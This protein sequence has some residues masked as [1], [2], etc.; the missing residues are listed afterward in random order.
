[1]ATPPSTPI[2]PNPAV[3]EP[4]EP[5]KKERASMKPMVSRIV[6]VAVTLL[7]LGVIVGV[8]AM[9]HLD[10]LVEQLEWKSYDLRT[11]IQ[12]GDSP[13]RPSQDIVILQ[14]DDPSLS[15]L[16]DD[17]GTWPWPRD[18]HARMIRYMN[19]VGVRRMLYDIMFVS[20]RKGEEKQDKALVDAFW[21]S[22]NVYLS[23]NFDQGL[24]QNRKLGK[25]L[26]PHDIELL[27]P[28]SINLTSELDKAPRDTRLRL[29]REP[30]GSIFFDNDHMTFNHYRS[31]LP[32]LLSKG[33]NIAIINHGAD[34][35]GVSRGNPLFFRFRYNDFVKTPY[36]PI[37]HKANGWWY[38]Q[39]GQR[40]DA[41]GYLLQQSLY[42]IDKR[43]DQKRPNGTFLDTTPGNP[44]LV[45]KEG[46]LMDE[47]GHSIYKRNAASSFLY[48]PYLGFRVMLDLKYPKT[49][50]PIRLTP[51]GHLKFGS[52]NI[53]LAANGDCLVTWYNISLSREDQQRGLRE[54]S[55]YL[56]ILHN[57]LN[58]LEQ[59]AQ[60]NPT[61]INQ[62][63]LASHRLEVQKAEFMAHRLDQLLKRDF[64]PQP[65]RTVAA[66]EVIRAMRRSEAG[67]PPTTEDQVL[68]QKLRD[69]I[70]FVGTTAVATYDIKN[71]PIY[72]SFPGVIF[73]ATL[74]DNLSR[75]KPHYMQRANPET[76]QWILVAICL[77]A[78]GLTLRVRSALVGVLTTVNIAILYVLG[79]IVLYQSMSLWINVAML[80]VALI[81]T[82]TLTFIAKYMLRDKD[83]E[84]T[85]ALA[86]TDS[87]T[88]LYNHRFFQDSMRQSID[89]ASRFKHSFSLL[90]IDIDFFKRFNDTYG[91]QT[92]DEVLRHVARKLQ[93]SVRVIDIVA[94]YG[95]EE[96]A[97]I[98]ARA[99]EEEAWAV[100]NKI[101]KAVAE[102]THL[103]GSGEA[104]QVTISCGIATYPM[105]G[106]TPSQL[107]EVADAGLY[108]AK[109]NGRNQVGSL[110]EQAEPPTSESDKA[111]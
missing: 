60:Q 25:D 101:V 90:L 9:F 20:H 44:Q 18:V 85:Y 83:Y 15:V 26:T 5:V 74:F 66:W 87:M 17:F 42:P 19:K 31:I 55:R 32:E 7:V 92:G 34:E 72:S 93:K 78:A 2:P 45:D 10:R 77:L 52:Y 24:E 30:D 49:I 39:K 110:P 111:E 103:I 22:P 73:Q 56:D 37:H 53:P 62:Q 21:E 54:M 65:Y 33:K 59:V 61:S 86:T 43:Q 23:M 70:V 36:L 4:A 99:T 84:K 16:S 8:F 71:T 68:V 11:Q 51:E 48:F 41:T 109:S 38:D 76:N 6:A 1:M 69:K 80:I 81:I 47:Y 57:T 40:T 102:E 95:G 28:L 13:N 106:I 46:Y 14:F 100:A 3:P 98:L 50:P 75:P 107:I 105:H 104:K 12:W 91:H 35:D 58:N 88:S 67:L 64:I 108:R 27:R 96:M 97:I 82:T 89:Q 94:R 63:N 29:R 79:A